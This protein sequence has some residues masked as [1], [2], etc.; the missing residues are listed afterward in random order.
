[1]RHHRQYNRDLARTLRQPG[2]IDVR[3]LGPAEVEYTL[4]CSGCGPVIFK[5]ANWWPTETFRR[6][7]AD[8]GWRLDGKRLKCPTC[9]EA[10]IAAKQAQRETTNVEPKPTLQV[11]SNDDRQPTDAARAVKRAIMQ[12]LDECYDTQAQRYRPTFGDA[13]IARETKAAESHVAKLREEF[14]GPAAPPMP[15]EIQAITDALAAQTLAVEEM[16]AKTHQALSDI[17]DPLERDHA[18]AG[19]AFAELK[20]R[21]DKLIAANGWS[22]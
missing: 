4:P 2:E 5:T 22:A 15:P 9:V 14:Y 11:V 12:W 21:L 18:D 17:G 20:G 13:S 16:K 19:K 3:N 10:E 7:L 6:N 1:M 8:R